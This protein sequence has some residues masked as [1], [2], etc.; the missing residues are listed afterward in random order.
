MDLA[1]E[2]GQSV[3]SHRSSQAE[4]QPAPHPSWAWQLLSVDLVRLFSTEIAWLCEPDHMTGDE[5]PSS[6]LGILKTDETAGSWLLTLY[7]NDE[8]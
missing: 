1:H 3:H 2:R 8:L 4:P 7:A 5:S 6:S